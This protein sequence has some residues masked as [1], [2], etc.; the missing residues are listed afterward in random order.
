[1]TKGQ[2]AMAVAMIY[3]DAKRSGRAGN[4]KE[5]NNSTINIDKGYI[6]QARTV[7]IHAPSLAD[8]VLA[9]AASLNDAY[10]EARN[11]KAI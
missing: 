11:A 2:R 5:L 9:G 3:P 4:K 1:M 6:S 10:Q 8:N 7:L